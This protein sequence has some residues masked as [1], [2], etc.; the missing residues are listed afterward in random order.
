MQQWKGIEKKMGISTRSCGAE[1]PLSGSTPL[2]PTNLATILD[3]SLLVHEPDEA[4]LAQHA[5]VPQAQLY[6]ALVDEVHGRAKLKR[7][8]RRVDVGGEVGRVCG[9]S[10]L[11]LLLLRLLLLGAG[12]RVRRADE[13]ICA[14]GAEGVVVGVVF[15]VGCFRV[16]GEGE[17]GAAAVGPVPAVMVAH[18]AECR[19]FR[20]EAV[21]GEFEVWSGDEA[22]EDAV[23]QDW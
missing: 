23:A 22:D 19:A 13:R 21:E 8:G 17:D 14:R 2:L 6:K 11:P 18:E 1:Y 10:L 20:L 9:L 4:A 5:N 16:G 7:D 15:V 12:V 3:K